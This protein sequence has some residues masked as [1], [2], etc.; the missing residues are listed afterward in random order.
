MRK[1]AY[2]CLGKLSNCSVFNVRVL[3]WVSRHR[4]LGRMSNLSVF[5]DYDD[6]DVVVVDVFSRHFSLARAISW[7]GP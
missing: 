1:H 7:I 2:R 4:Y 5:N 6:D 3:E